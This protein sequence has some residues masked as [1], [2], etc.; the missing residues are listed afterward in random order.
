VET[1]KTVLAIDP[2][3]NKC[4]LALVR[5]DGDGK[6]D[7]VWSAIAPR[8]SVL[9]SLQE[10]QEKEAYSMIIVGSGT[11]SKPLVAEIRAEMP[12]MAILVVDEKDTSFQARERYWE[13]NP[14]RGWRRLLPSTLQT[15]PEPVDNYA[16][17]VIAE[18]VLIA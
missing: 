12:S 10:A 2:G 17:L 14:R 13:H 3:K 6:L 15:P 7:L 9:A 5:R 11:T 4:G 1:S 8:E 16:A 18:R